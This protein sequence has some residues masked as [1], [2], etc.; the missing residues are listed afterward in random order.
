[1]RDPEQRVL[2]RSRR[3]IT[4]QIAAVI[5]LVVTLVGALAYCVMV[6][7]QRSDMSRT[8]DY[9]LSNNSVANPPACVWLYEQT[10]GVVKASPGAPAGLLP[11][12]GPIQQVAAGHAA[13]SASYTVAGKSY[14]A[15]TI[16]RG[17]TI[18]Q[19]VL[20]KR[21]QNDDKRWL[22]IALG[23]A[24]V[25]GLLA[26]AVTGGVLARRAIAPLGE[27][28]ARQRRFVA[29]ASHELRT[30]L[31]QLHTRA[32]LLDQQLRADGAPPEVA[33]EVAAMVAST[34]QFGAVVEDLLLS[35]QLRSAPRAFGLVNLAA[36][37]TAAVAADQPRARAGGIVLAADTEACVVRGVESAL[38]R[39]VSAL[40]DNAIGHSQ[41]GGRID[42]SL[43]IQD[44]QAL[45]AVSDTGV[46]F[47]QRDAGRLFDRFAR[48]DNGA[49]RRFG[50]GLALVREVV[51][52]HGGRISAV[53]VPGAGAKFTVSLPA[54]S[55]QSVTPRARTREPAHN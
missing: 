1:M 19:A 4:I 48:G 7:G 21:F 9:A 27:A 51:E 42:V 43:S 29:D 8:L 40:I 46:G 53:G 44:G 35:A 30:P 37:V 10:G 55:A 41:E 22:L 23:I 39:V 47:D 11:I 31:T 26:A 33:G 14:E 17:N 12:R 6:R 28:L 2:A 45:V 52:S 24:E 49:G 25:V 16:R 36:V 54:V 15:R 34:R 50:L 13:I 38:R 20:D 5:T 3:L 18:V 32:Q